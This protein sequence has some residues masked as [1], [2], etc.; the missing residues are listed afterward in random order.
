M[1]AANSPRRL[2]GAFVARFGLL[3]IGDF[4][5]ELLAESGVL[6]SDGGLSG[7]GATRSSD[8]FRKMFDLFVAVEEAAEDFSGLALTGTAR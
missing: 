4:V 6:D 8:S 3:E 5:G 7:Y 2:D 1:M